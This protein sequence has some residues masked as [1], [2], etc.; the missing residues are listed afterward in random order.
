MDEQ[1]NPYDPET[2][3]EKCGHADIAATFHEVQ[4]RMCQDD[5]C[6]FFRFGHMKRHCRNCSFQWD[7]LPLCDVP[8]P[9]NKLLAACERALIEFKAMQASGESIQQSLIDKVEDAIA[10]EGVG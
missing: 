5:A 6:W 8:A 4:S 7:E 2:I 10:D 1:L 3:C 9:H